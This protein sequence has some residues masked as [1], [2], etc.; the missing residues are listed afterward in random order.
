MRVSEFDERAFWERI[1]AGDYFVCGESYEH[2]L[3]NQQ[4]PELDIQRG[5]Q[6]CDCAGDIHLDIRQRFNE[7]ESHVDYNLHADCDQRRRVEHIHSD[8]DR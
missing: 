6:Y 5:E 3:R 4:R 8:R 2:H 1:R 7:F